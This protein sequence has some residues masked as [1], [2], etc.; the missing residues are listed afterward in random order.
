MDNV[1]LE[2]TS[3]LTYAAPSFPRVIVVSV[4]WTIIYACTRMRINNYKKLIMFNTYV[5]IV[6]FF[7]L[8]F[9]CVLAQGGAKGFELFS[10]MNWKALF[11]LKVFNL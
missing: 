11:V 1:E 10:S 8:L 5:T 4:A 2:T 6:L 7:L 3:S 9:V